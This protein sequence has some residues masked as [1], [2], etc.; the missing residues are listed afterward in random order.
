LTKQYCSSSREGKSELDEGSRKDTH[1][2]SNSNS[3]SILQQKGSGQK[4]QQ[5]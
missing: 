5:F 2:E 3:V 1:L 4:E